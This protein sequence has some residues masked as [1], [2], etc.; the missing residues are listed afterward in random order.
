MEGKAK[1]DIRAPQGQVTTAEGFADLVAVGKEYNDVVILRAKG[2][3]RK[4]PVAGKAYQQ[5][6]QAILQLGFP[7]KMQHAIC[8][9]FFQLPILMGSWSCAQMNLFLFV[10]GIKIQCA[11]LIQ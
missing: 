2:K 9:S 10:I 1:I 11:P 7:G 8:L 4:R 6:K 3:K 5:Y